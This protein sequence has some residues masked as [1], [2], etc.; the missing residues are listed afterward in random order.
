MIRPEKA[1]GRSAKINIDAIHLIRWPPPL[2]VV[3]SADSQC[4]TDGPDIFRS[5][6]ASSAAE[7]W[8]PS[9]GMCGVDLNI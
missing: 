4:G 8:Q 2:S 6:S 7:W 1:L 9:G 3:Y 5:I